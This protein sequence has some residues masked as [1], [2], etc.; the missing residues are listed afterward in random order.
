LP[1]WYRANRAALIERNGGLVY[2]T[3]FDIVR[4]YLW[5]PHDQS[6]HPHRQIPAE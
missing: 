2:A 6:L 5:R 3:Y 4:R 1:R